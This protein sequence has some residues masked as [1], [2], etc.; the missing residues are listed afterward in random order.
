MI[1]ELI[2][3]FEDKDDVIWELASRAIMQVASVERGR[4]YIVTN[5]L[6]IP[7]AKLFEDDVVKIRSN[8]YFTML[9]VAD[10]LFGIDSV[11]DFDINVI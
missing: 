9:W 11:I 1:E 3:C 5:K 10:F 8:A 2:V 4:D 7:I 6:V